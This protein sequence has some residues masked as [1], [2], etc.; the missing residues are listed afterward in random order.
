VKLGIV[1]PFSWD[2]PG[3]VQV[4][5]RDLA[6]HLIGDGHDV[7]VLAPGDEDAIVEPY[8]VSVGRALPIRH[9]GSVARVAFGPVSASRVRRWIREGEFDVMHVHSPI[10]PSIGMIACWAALGP[11]VATFHASYEGRVRSMVAGYG[12]LSVTLEKVQARIAV[13]EEARRTVVQH[14]G[15]DAVLIPNG[16]ETKSFAHAVPL[17]GRRRGGEVLGFLG[18]LDEPR[19]GLHVLLEAFPGIAAARP[20]ARLLVI[21]P[22]DVDDALE[23]LPEHLRSRAEFLGR[24]SDADKARALA[25]VDVMIAPNTGGESFGIVLLEAMAAGAP[26][27]A[28][29]LVAFRAVLAGGRGGVLVPV[30]DASALADATIDLLADP[31]RRATLAQHGASIARQYDWDSVARQIVDVYAT[32]AVPGVVVTEDDRQGPGIFAGRLRRGGAS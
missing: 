17:P 28:S 15:G 23:Q 10:S 16:V 20:D 26:V 18:R 12:L 19:K 21:G 22:G 5:V 2:V 31:G 8:V 32:V 7:S 14:L 11:I 6:E 4:H 30:A 13:S 24:V 3:G 1:C 9:N 25:S 27:V 29:D